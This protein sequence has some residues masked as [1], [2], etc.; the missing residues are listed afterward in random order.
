LLYY[1]K[2]VVLHKNI[3]NKISLENIY[4]EKIFNFK[5]YFIIYFFIKEYLN[6]YIS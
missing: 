3:K 4:K 1:I 2:I 5:E 6:I